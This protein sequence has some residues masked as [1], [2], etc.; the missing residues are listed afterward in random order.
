MK[1]R[2]RR[3]VAVLVAAV[4]IV[5]TAWLIDGERRSA[6]AYNRILEWGYTG[7][8]LSATPVT[9][10]ERSSLLATLGQVLGPGYRIGDGRYAVL[11]GDHRRPPLNYSVRDQLG[12]G[13]PPGED[14]VFVRTV[15]KDSA[16]GVALWRLGLIGA[17]YV[18]A[19]DH[20]ATDGQQNSRRVVG[21]FQVSAA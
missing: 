10:A 15:A 17:R 21:Y 6:A 13:F 7:Q 4:A 16:E 18:A 12:S 1:R 11:T 8:D 3:I 20:R 2:N 19:V 14:A 9:R 5:G